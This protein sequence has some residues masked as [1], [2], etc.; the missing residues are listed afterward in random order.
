MYLEVYCLV[1]CGFYEGHQNK[2]AIEM[3]GNWCEKAGIKWGEEVGIGAGGMIKFARKMGW[4]HLIKIN[5]L[6][7]KD[8]FLKK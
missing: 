8:L 4:R 7:R 6:K 1:N 3:M 5:E 2:L